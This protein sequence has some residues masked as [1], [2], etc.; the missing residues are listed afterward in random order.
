MWCSHLLLK[1]RAKETSKQDKTYF[2]LS[3]QTRS[4][5]EGFFLEDFADYANEPDRVE[6]KETWSDCFVSGKYGT[7]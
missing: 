4:V 5:S 3:P 6:E 7:N 2:I 1:H